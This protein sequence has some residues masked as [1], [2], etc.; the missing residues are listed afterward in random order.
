MHQDQ[1]KKIIASRIDQDGL[2][3]TGIAGVKLFRA[4]QAMPCAPAV[5]EPSVIAIVAG[6]K[7]A[8][9]DGARY[10]YDNTQYM[11]CPMSMPVLS[12]IHI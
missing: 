12:L 7:E 4:T 9:L 1:I 11:C 2:F 8:V 6:S 3:E 5:Y 10:V